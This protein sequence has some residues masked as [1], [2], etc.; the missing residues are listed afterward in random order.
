[1]KKILLASCV[2]ALVTGC[3][4]PQQQGA[5]EGAAIGAVLGGVLCAVAGG[6]ASTCA[7][8][9]GASAALGG[10]VGYTYANN[11]EKR[12]QAL[13]GRENDMNARLE[14]VRGVNQDSER[15]NAELQQKMQ[16]AARQ[17]EQFQDQIAA[18]RAT[19]QQIAQR[20][21]KL[22]REISDANQQVESMESALEDMRRFRDSNAGQASPQLDQQIETLSQTL[23][24]ARSNTQALAGLRQ[25]V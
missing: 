6:N 5:S 7:A 9:A 2:A 4:N 22:D 24:Q 11:V 20:R 21:N 19:Q 18:G 25:R 3:A 1:M 8:V 10:A 17:T 15:F 13:A 14:Y 12:R 16:N 23:D